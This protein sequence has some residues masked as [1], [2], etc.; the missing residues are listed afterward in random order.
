MV[1]LKNLVYSEKRLWLIFE[2]LEKDLKKYMD[3]YGKVLPPKIVKA[4]TYQMMRG[5][6]EC[7][8]K[9]IVHRDMKPQN[10]LIGKD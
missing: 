9:R 7:H 5:L 10:L 8:A 2:F 4:F 6:A 3:T 1:P